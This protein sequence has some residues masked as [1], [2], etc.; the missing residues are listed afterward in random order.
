MEALQLGK[1]VTDV[2]VE[3]S[4]LLAFQALGYRRPTQNQ[5]EAIRAFVSG[6][7]I[8]SLYSC[9]QVSLVRRAFVSLLF[10]CSIVVVSAA[11]NG[12]PHFVKDVF[13]RY[14][15]SLRGARVGGWGRDYVTSTW[16]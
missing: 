1:T 6:R 2:A 16:N 5:Q 7:D 15:T 11:L 4:T 8:L 12:K 3:A 9:Q 13:K 14:Q 10:L